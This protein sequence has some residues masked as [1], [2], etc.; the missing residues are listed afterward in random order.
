M[1]LPSSAPGRAARFAL[2]VAV[3]AVLTAGFAVAFRAALFRVVHVASGADGLV[4]AM[5]A[6]PWWLRLVLPAAGGLTAGLLVQRATRGSHGVGAVMEAVA[7]GRVRLSLRSTLWRALATWC[8]IASGGSIGRE[9]PLIQVGGAVAKVTGERLG[10][11]GD[12]LRIAIACGCAAGFTAAYNTPFAAVLFVLEIVIGVIVVEAVV[13]IVIATVI[14]TVLTRAVVGAVP[15]YGERTFTLGAP[16]E[17]LAFA[18]VGVVAALAGHAFVRVLHLGA[19][20]FARVPLP[21]RAGLGGLCAGAVVVGVPEVAGNGYEPLA[22]L[23]DGRFAIGMVALLMIAKL[24]ATTS[25]VSSGS[26]GGV[27][28]PIMLIGGGAGV[29][30][31][32]ALDRLGAGPLAPAGGYALVG[33][34]AATA[35][36]THAPLMAAVMAFELSSDYAIVLPLALATAIATATARWLRRDSVYTAELAAPEDW[37]LSLDGRRGAAAD[38]PAR[39][40]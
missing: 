37:P 6:A 10:L 21:W 17:L 8:A 29:L 20:A 33:M 28:T 18:L 13:P 3:I 27:F 22:G 36:T 1:S 7:L 26:P 34:A 4:A 32:A 16:A 38:D 35:A 25:S 12:R 31:A 14:A 11:A 9:G 2:A 5:I 19:R 24:V 39:S 23:L 30:V 40:G 15:L